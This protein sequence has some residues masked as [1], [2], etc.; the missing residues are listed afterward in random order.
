MPISFDG[1]HPPFLEWTSEVRGFLQLND[2]GFLTNLDTAF[3]EAHP[4]T[5]NDV[6]GGRD[7]TEDIDNGIRQHQEGLA[8][9]NEEHAQR[10]QPVA[11]G[12]S[13]RRAE[14]T[15]TADIVA[16]Q[17]RGRATTSRSTSSTATTARRRRATTT[18]QRQGQEQQQR[19]R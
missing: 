11:A 17:R 16:M 3:S 10:D 9:L 13:A 18:T 14:A 6:Y 12:Q 5:L 7:N 19:E 8:A 2:F 4:V 15:I 1:N